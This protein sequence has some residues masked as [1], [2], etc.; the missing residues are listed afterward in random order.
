VALD[1]LSGTVDYTTCQKRGGI[2]DVYKVIFDGGSEK[3]DDVTKGRKGL[4]FLTSR[5]V[6]YGRPLSEVVQKQT[7]TELENFKKLYQKLVK[8]YDSS[9]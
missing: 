9:S 8:V 6:I 1:G 7:L 5:D 4:F 3:C 2:V